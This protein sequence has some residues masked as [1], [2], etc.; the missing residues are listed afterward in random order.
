M[1]RSAVS[2]RRQNRRHLRRIVS[3]RATA[4]RLSKRLNVGDW[5]VFEWRTAYGEGGLREG[6]VTSLSDAD[7]PSMLTVAVP[8]TLSH[9]VRRG[10]IRR[11]GCCRVP[12]R[13]AARLGLPGTVGD[14]NPRP[15]GGGLS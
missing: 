10:A 13:V 4:A 9:V 5:V 11:R 1:T 7:H 8:G 12:E 15:R 14:T 6:R 3:Q 2:A